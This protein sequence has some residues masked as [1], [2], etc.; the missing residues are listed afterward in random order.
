MDGHVPPLKTTI[1]VKVALSSRPWKLLSLPFPSGLPL[2]EDWGYCVLFCGLGFP[3]L[4]HNFINTLFSKPSSDYPNWTVLFHITTL[5]E[6][7]SSSFSL[8]FKFPHSGATIISYQDYQV[9]FLLLLFMDQKLLKVSHHKYSKIQ[10]PY[11]GPRI[12]MIRLL[13]NFTLSHI[14]LLG[15]RAHQVLFCLL[16]TLPGHFCFLLF[17]W[18]AMSKTKTK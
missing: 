1:L 7:E 12:C 3:Y 10:I 4:A 17:I 15:T 8:I 16:F 13:F 18:L 5:T 9:I 11:H 2:I 14:H 6:T